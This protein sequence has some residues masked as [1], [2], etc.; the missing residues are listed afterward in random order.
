MD[1]L[2]DA[3]KYTVSNRTLSSILSDGMY[4]AWSV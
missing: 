4:Q 3:V 1:V 2:T